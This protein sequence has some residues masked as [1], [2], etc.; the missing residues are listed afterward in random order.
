MN[1]EK[2][3]LEEVGKYLKPKERFGVAVSGGVDSVVLLDLVGRFATWFQ[4]K[5][6][7]LHLDHGLRGRES[8]K[9]AILVERTAKK[10]GLS[11]IR[12]RENI[13]LKSRRE[14]LSLEEAGRAARLGFFRN[15]G[16][17]HRF[18]K[19]L[20]AH[21]QDDLIETVLMRLF[22]GT[23]PRGLRA[24]EAVTHIRKLALI[25]PL[26]NIN[27]K[28]LRAFAAKH[29]IV[30]R[31]DMSNRDVNFF[32][33]RIRNQVIP[34]LARTLGDPIFGKLLGFRSSLALSQDFISKTSEDLFRRHWKTSPG[35][36]RAP[37]KVSR[38]LY[39][40]LHPAMQYGTLSLAYQTVAGK[41]LEQKEWRK[42]EKVVRGEVSKVNLRG[43]SFFVRE[44]GSFV[45]KSP[46]SGTVLAELKNRP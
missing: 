32:R 23:G 12:A 40:R 37:L 9:D 46:L 7:I 17:Q 1:L 43:N 25:R 30:Y 44:N 41:V 4:W 28:T 18:K 33:N 3:F 8:E 29:H 20:L 27:K 11:F 10:L 34:Y 26:L 2:I 16:R 24:M 45:L 39:E 42:V 13:Q 5:P 36:G 6:F 38:R 19:I 21:H 15:A 35:R 22:R 14:K 31:E